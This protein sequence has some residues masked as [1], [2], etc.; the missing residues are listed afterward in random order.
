MTG[1]HKCV[2]LSAMPRLGRQKVRETL[3]LRWDPS[4]L[5]DLRRALGL[6]EAQLGTYIGRTAYTII[7]WERGTTTP[8]ARDLANLSNATSASILSF[9]RV[10][11][12]PT[13]ESRAKKTIEA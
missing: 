12:E 3:P 9:Y 7:G 10:I 4:K 5:R 2:I 11:D 6:T 13:S 8:T 1:T